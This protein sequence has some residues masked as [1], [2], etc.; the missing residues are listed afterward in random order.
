M[1][2]SG[3]LVVSVGGGEGRLLVG[4]RVSLVIELGAGAARRMR[5][6]G[7]GQLTVSDLQLELSI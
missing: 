2:M 4:L 5:D 6:R 7:H 1:L 3:R